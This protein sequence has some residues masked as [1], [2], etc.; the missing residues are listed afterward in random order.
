M[1]GTALTQLQEWYRGLT[2][3][4]STHFP[5]IPL[6]PPIRTGT[7][8]NPIIQTQGARVYYNNGFLGSG[9]NQTSLGGTILSGVLGGL[10]SIF[11][12]PTAT[13]PT[14]R[15]PATLPGGETTVTQHPVL[16]GAG[17]ASGTSGRVGTAV[18]V[19][20]GVAGAIAGTVAPTVFGLGG[21]HRARYAPPG[22]KGYHMIRKGP[23]AGQWTR[24]RHRNVANIRAL[25]RAL[26]RAHGFERICR[27]VMHFVNPHKRGRAVF[28]RRRRR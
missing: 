7:E 24:N 23:H 4:P 13:V 5:A 21:G 22:T 26:S 10:E 12:F 28:K 18:A 1:P 16:T 8:A 27:K 14:A 15:T 2:F 3:G 17:G 25:R 19:G 11:H 6:L 9:S 20:T